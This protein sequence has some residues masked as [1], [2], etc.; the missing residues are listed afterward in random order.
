MLFGVCGGERKL[1]AGPPILRK[2]WQRKTNVLYLGFQGF[3]QII[4]LNDRDKPIIF[5]YKYEFHIWPTQVMASSSLRLCLG[6][7]IKR[8]IA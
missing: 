3:C 8:E 6:S 7:D 5:Q 4:N 2:I 1:G